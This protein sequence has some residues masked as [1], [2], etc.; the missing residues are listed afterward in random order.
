MAKETPGIRI[1]LEEVFEIQVSL[2][3]DTMVHLTNLTAICVKDC[4]LL[5]S[6]IDDAF[7][8]DALAPG[9]YL[10]IQP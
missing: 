5:I 8:N 4:E 1:R 3:G 2:S 9:L 6:Y 7:I 10:T